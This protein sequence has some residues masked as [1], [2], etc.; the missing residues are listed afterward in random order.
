MQHLASVQLGQ[1]VEYSGDLSSDFAFRPSFLRLGEVDSEVA[2]NCVLESQAIKQLAI[3]RDNWESVVYRDRPLMAVEQ[4]AEVGLPEPAVD[5]GAG[6][7]ADDLWDEVRAAEPMREED[8]AE[9]ALSEQSLDSVLNPSLGA[10][11]QSAGA[12][13]LVRLEGAMGRAE[14][15]G[16]SR[17]GM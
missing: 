16:G 11:D 12:E 2:V 5:P 8:L 14:Y 1:H 15:S 13:V 9:P 10:F 4:L 3:A 6:L 7:D 17:R